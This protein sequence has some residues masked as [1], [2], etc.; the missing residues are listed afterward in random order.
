M[1][2]TPLLIAL[3][4]LPILPSEVMAALADYG[5]PHTPELVFLLPKDGDNVP[6]Y[7][8]NTIKMLMDKGY[9]VER[10][11]DDV[12]VNRSVVS[13]LGVPIVEDLRETLQNRK[14]PKETLGYIND[15]SYEPLV[16]NMA[17]VRRKISRLSTLRSRL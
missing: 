12:K 3:Q 2:A 11:Y 1:K 13:N 5:F 14:N 15:K 6:R 8:K 4:D 10:F 17:R 9:D 16:R 7:K